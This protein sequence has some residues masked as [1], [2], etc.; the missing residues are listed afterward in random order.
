MIYTTTFTIRIE[1]ETL[2]ALDEAAERKRMPR[3]RLLLQIIEDYL[4]GSGDGEKQDQ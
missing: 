3:N 2:K 4:N 1:V